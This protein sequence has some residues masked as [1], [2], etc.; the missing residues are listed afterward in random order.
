MPRKK[1]NVHRKKSPRSKKGGR[2]KRYELKPIQSNVAGIDVGSKSHWVAGP[3]IE[4]GEPNVE[5]FGTTTGELHRL[6]KWLQDQGVTSVAMESTGVY[7]I[8]VLE[9]L[10]DY[11]IEV[12]LGNARQL[13]HVPG[14]K[15]DIQDCQWLQLL[16]AHGL[17]K[18]SFRPAREV[19]EFRELTRMLDVLKRERARW[20]QRMQ[21]S[22][23]QMNI[24][25]HHAV[26]DITGLTGLKILRAIVNGERDP[27]KLAALR[28]PRCHK[29]VEEIAAHLQGTWRR[30]HLATLE[31]AL[32]KY[33]QYTE[34]ILEYERKIA[35]WMEEMLPEEQKS[36]PVPAHRSP[37]KGQAI[38][39]A[40]KE[41][42]REALY[43]VWGGI[44]LT[45]VDGV[46]VDTALVVTTELGVDYSRFPTEDHFASYITLAPHT[47]T[48][49]GKRLPASGP[50]MGCSRVAQALKMAASTLKNSHTALG[51]Y[52]R[53][54][55]RRKG[56]AVAIFATA[57]K[58]AKLIYRLVR[59]GEAYIDEGEE[60]YEARRLQRRIHVSERTLK[61]LGYTIIPPESVVAEA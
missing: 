20:I 6:A 48:S 32:K 12:L 31:T 13:K 45:T 36:M 38:K 52:Y 61:S 2:S 29:S 1:K 11:G 17:V 7:W 40:G 51:A 19:C 35:A 8:P 22:L 37:S 28:D 5:E 34:D 41:P 23:D 14:R 49:G 30:E 59:Y 16:H 21:K 3:Q 33:D 57:R 46:A 42:I 56:K 53:D 44:D 27:M 43:R 60:A 55:A 15:S 10:E 24:R 18:G 50:P 4:D 26:S 39:K 9:V 58:I 25:V 47:A 54:I